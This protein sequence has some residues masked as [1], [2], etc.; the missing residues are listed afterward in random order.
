MPALEGMAC[1]IVPIVSNRS[2]LPEVVGDVGLLVNPD[3][4]EHVAE[5]L[6]KS[7]SDNEWYQDQSKQAVKRAK[8]F[9]WKRSAEIA[10]D[11][12]TSFN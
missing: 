4:A 5:A 10:L 6:E 1:G 8:N 9:S 7:L 12:Y 11:V 2:S 3:E